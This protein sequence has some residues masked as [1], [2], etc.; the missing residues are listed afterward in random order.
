VVISFKKY[1]CWCGE[2]GGIGRVKLCQMRFLCFV[3][4][5]VRSGFG[6]Y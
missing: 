3:Y 2:D 4:D 6:M 5:G 1:Y